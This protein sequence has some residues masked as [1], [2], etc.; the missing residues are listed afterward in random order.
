M[1]KRL[2]GACALMIIATSAAAQNPNVLL[3]TSHGDI[4]IE[5]NEK[6]APISVE[7]FL[8]YADAGHYDGL[9]FHRVIPG[10]M[11]Q[12]GGFTPDMRQR[13]VGQP[14]KNE[15]DNGLLNTRYTLAMAR[16]QVVD[17]ATSQFFINLGSNDFLN[18]GGRDFGY[19]VFGEVVEGQHV[20]ETIAKVPTGNQG[21]HQNVP[22]NPVTIISAKRVDASEE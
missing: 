18:H 10:F 13:D 12:G 2:M 22:T 7:N 20:V 19:A 16:T 5:L 4:L 21:M 11:I 17:S 9:I 6:E 3:H 14:I 8:R 1:L 15:A